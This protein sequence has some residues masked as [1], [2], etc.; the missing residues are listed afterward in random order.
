MF[1]KRGHSAVYK[2]NLKKKRPRLFI[3]FFLNQTSGKND[4]LDR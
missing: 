4:P 3:P 1:L 2:A